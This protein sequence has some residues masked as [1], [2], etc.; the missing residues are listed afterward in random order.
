MSRS[1]DRVG[2]G[3]GRRYRCCGFFSRGFDFFGWDRGKER[4]RRN[5]RSLNE[6]GIPEEESCLIHDGKS[7]RRLRRDEAIHT[8]IRARQGGSSHL[9]HDPRGLAE[10]VLAPWRNFSGPII[11]YGELRSPGCMR[12]GGSGVT[13]GGYWER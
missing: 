1:R 8:P 6:R 11:A 9:Y 2:L 10:G 13:M 5:E 4:K 3:V 12:G 7:V